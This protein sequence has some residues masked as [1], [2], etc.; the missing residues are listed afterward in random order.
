MIGRQTVHDPDLQDSFTM[1]VYPMRTAKAE[2]S[3]CQPT[4]LWGCKPVG[5]A[6]LSAS[7]SVR[8]R[9]CPPTGLSQPVGLQASGPAGQSARGLES[10]TALADQSV[11]PCA[12]PAVGLSDSQP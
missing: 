9:V 1:A 2:C 7:G 6:G 8:Q 11:S 4:A 5:P 10:A 12:N 3:A